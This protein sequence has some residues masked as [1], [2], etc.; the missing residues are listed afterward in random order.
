MPHNEAFEDSR[1]VPSFTWDVLWRTA[2]G[3]AME[4][5]RNVLLILKE[6]TVV[7][8]D[9]GRE[10]RRWVNT[11]TYIAV[12]PVFGVPPCAGTKLSTSVALAAVSAWRPNS[13]TCTSPVHR[14]MRWNAR[15]PLTS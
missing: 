6:V 3:R 15:A 4:T 1:F 7:T 8:A 5:R 11:V 10:R 12:S 14:L 2:V 9:G 13:R